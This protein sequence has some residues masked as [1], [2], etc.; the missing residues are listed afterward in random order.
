MP[1]TLL[2]LPKSLTGQVPGILVN[3][4]VYLAR[5]R[6]TGSGARTL[7][8]EKGRGRVIVVFME[9]P[10]WARRLDEAMTEGT[11]LLAVQRSAWRFLRRA[12]DHELHDEVVR[13]FAPHALIEPSRLGRP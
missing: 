4:G 3:A 7:T 2:V 8:C 1:Q 10:E 9:A 6:E 11:L 5:D 12:D 13:L